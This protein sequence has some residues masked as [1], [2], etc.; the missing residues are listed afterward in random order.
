[1]A[2]AEQIRTRHAKASGEKA[3]RVERQG[4]SRQS[5]SSREHVFRHARACSGD[6][7]RR[8]RAH[9][10]AVM[11]MFVVTEVHPIIDGNRRIARLAMNCMLSAAELSRIMIPT[12]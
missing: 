5:K 9:W 1:M 3:R 6:A 7:T 2:L 4:K 12:V 8:F 11:T 10:R